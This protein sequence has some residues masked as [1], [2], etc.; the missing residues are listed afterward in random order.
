M[1]QNKVEVKVPN[2]SAGAESTL[3][4]V[5]TIELI[6]GIILA[7]VSFLG[8]ENHAIGIGGGLGIFITSL[9]TW[10]TLNVF[11]NIS[12]RLKAI[13]E[14]MPLKLVDAK[15]KPSDTSDEVNVEISVKTMPYS[16]TPSAKPEREV[17]KGDRILFRTTKRAVIVED[18]RP[19][20]V[21]VKASAISGYKWLPINDFL[22]P[23]E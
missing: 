10:A 5:A 3:K 14:T 21:F 2:I 11:A 8:V 22:I 15:Q 1:E 17:K 18:V 4:T 20:E 6:C 12:L 9:V 19:G 7:L 16:D 23:E 13:Q